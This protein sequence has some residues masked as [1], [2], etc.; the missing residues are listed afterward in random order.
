[1]STT[2]YDGHKA[3]LIVLRVVKIDDSGSGDNGDDHSLTLEP[4]DSTP[5]TYLS[6]G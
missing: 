1:M 3:A 4:K 5:K 2:L 6:S